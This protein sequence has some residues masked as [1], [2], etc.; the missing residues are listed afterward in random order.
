MLVRN[1]NDLQRTVGSQQETMNEQN[2]AMAGIIKQLEGTQSY[3]LK[4]PIVQGI[5]LNNIKL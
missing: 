1:L 5:F 4:A 3:K 2:K